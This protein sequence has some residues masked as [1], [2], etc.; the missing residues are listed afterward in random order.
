MMRQRTQDPTQAGEAASSLDQLLA[1]LNLPRDLHEGA[2][3]VAAWDFTFR[4]AEGHVVAT[5]S[6]PANLIVNQGLNYWRDSLA[7]G[8]TAIGSWF[9]GLLGAAPTV[10]AADTMASHAGWT[11][12]HAIYSEAARPAWT[13]ATAGAGGR[14]NAAARAR[15]TFT[16]SGTVG[17]A[18][19][20]SSSTKNGTTGTLFSGRAFP[21]G[22][23][24]VANGYTLDV[25]LSIT[26]TA[27]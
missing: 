12:V 11:E 26:V 3:V 2:A 18:F 4:D 5:R 21:G 13:T 10:A 16:G 20:T 14:T 17:G 1:S 8:F 19:L 9:I 15:F 27:S 23:V 22:D 24:G 6:I 25:E 7:S